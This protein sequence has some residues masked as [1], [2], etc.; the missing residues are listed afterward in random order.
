MSQVLRLLW[1]CG[2]SDPFTCLFISLSPQSTDHSWRTDLLCCEWLF[3]LLCDL[4]R[5]VFPP[6]VSFF[7]IRWWE[8]RPSTPTRSYSNLLSDTIAIFSLKIAFFRFFFVRQ[9]IPPSDLYC[10]HLVI[11]PWSHIKILTTNT[12]RTLE[13]KREKYRFVC[14]LK[15][16]RE[17]KKRNCWKIDPQKNFLL[18]YIYY[19]CKFIEPFYNLQNSLYH[20]WKNHLSEIDDQWNINKITLQNAIVMIFDSC[21]RCNWRSKIGFCVSDRRIYVVLYLHNI[22]WSRAILTLGG[23]LNLPLIDRE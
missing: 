9:L 10:L 18:D 12:K 2:A 3:A 23:F 6:H 21:Q 1:N 11:L 20:S 19:F 16:M 15:R 22:M 7:T 14:K 17:T 5:V 13:K 8:I 4:P